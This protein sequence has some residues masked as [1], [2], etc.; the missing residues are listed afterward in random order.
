MPKMS[1]DMDT[2]KPSSHRSISEELLNS[3]ELSQSSCEGLSFESMQDIEMIDNSTRQYSVVR[4]SC[5]VTVNVGENVTAIHPEVLDVLNNDVLGC[6][7][8]LPASTHK[9]VRRTKIW[10]N[11]RYVLF[12][13]NLLQL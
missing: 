3:R 11:H 7:S 12:G 8:I 5:G 4:L 13:R 10:I 2:T 6:I 1:A 9:L